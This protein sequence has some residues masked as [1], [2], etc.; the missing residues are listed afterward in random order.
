MKKISINLRINRGEILNELTR[1]SP[2]TALAL[3]PVEGADVNFV[4]KIVLSSDDYPWC[5]DKF[6]QLFYKLRDILLPFSSCGDCFADMQ[7]DDFSFRI[8]MQTDVQES[9]INYIKEIMT[10]YILAE[11]FLERVPEKSVYLTTQCDNMMTLLKITLNRGI[12]RVRRPTQ[13]F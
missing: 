2:Y 8:N 6:R 3:N 9:V 10:N 12:S 7:G 4:D 13:Y 11:W 1:R 5:D